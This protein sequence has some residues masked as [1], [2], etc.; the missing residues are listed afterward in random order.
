VNAYGIQLRTL[1]LRFATQDLVHTGVGGSTSDEVFVGEALPV[2]DDA[3]AF[4]FCFPRRLV[5]DS[6]ISQSL[7]LW[8]NNLM[9]CFVL[10]A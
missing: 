4:P 9:N 3:S 7:P 8:K 2:A 5:S 1:A 6:G 10:A